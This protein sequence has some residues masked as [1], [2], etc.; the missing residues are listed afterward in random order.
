MSS[1]VH[2]DSSQTRPT[3]SDGMSTASIKSG[4]L[5]FPQSEDSHAALPNAVIEDKLHSTHALDPSAG[6]ASG[7]KYVVSTIH[8]EIINWYSDTTNPSYTNRDANLGAGAL[9]AGTGPTAHE[10]HRQ[11]DHDNLRT[12]TM[13]SDYTDS[14]H[15]STA[16]SEQPFDRSFDRQQSYTTATDR[17][18][19]LSGGVVSD[20]GAG[21]PSNTYASP[22]QTS[23]LPVIGGATSSRGA[24]KPSSTFGSHTHASPAQT[25]TLPIIG[26]RTSGRYAENPSS[27]FG[28][29]S[30]PMTSEREPGT[31]ER[32]AGLSD[33]H[34]REALAGA[35]A[36]V[37]IAGSENSGF[38]AQIRQ[39]EHEHE[40]ERGPA[41]T[42]AA[43]TP[44]SSNLSSAPYSSNA[45]KIPVGSNTSS[46]P[47]ASSTSSAPIFN[48]TSSA[49]ISSNT[50]NIPVP[51]NTS[52]DPMSSNSSSIPGP[53][54]TSTAPS[55]SSILGAP[56]SS[57]T[58]NAPVSDD[59]LNAPYG[60]TSGPHV[61]DTANRL[62][63][64]L[65]VPGEFP[66]TPLET[67]GARGPGF[68]SGNIGTIDEYPT[69]PLT[70][71]SSTRDSPQLGGAPSSDSQHHYG[72]DAA[73]TGGVGAAGLRAYE[74]GKHHQGETTDI[75]NDATPAFSSPYSSTQIDP[76][77]DSR[78]A[79]FEEQRFDPTAPTKP[80][81]HDSQHHG[82]DAALAGGALA[83]ARA[84]GYAAS[85]QSTEPHQSSQPV[86]A[87]RETF[88]TSGETTAQV[89][90]QTETK[91]QSEHHYGRDAGL[92]GAGAAGG[93]YYANQQG[94][95][96]DTG[97]AT[98]TIGPHKSN[99]A[100][101]LDPCVQPD[102][103]LQQHRETGPTAEDP[104]TAT[105]GPH[106]SNV[107][108]ILDPRVQPDPSKQKQHVTTGPHQS[109]TLNRLDPKVDAH[110]QQSESQHH[111]GRDAGVVGGTGAAGYGAYEAAQK[112]DEHRST[113]PT[114]SLGEQRYYPTAHGAH[115]P[116]QT[117]Q[118][119][120]GRDAAVAGGLGTAGAEAYAASRPHDRTEEPGFSQGYQQSAAHPPYDS[121]QDPNAQGQSHTNR[122]LAAAGGAAGLAG[123]GAYA[124][125]KQQDKDAEKERLAHQ[126]AQEKELEHQHKEQQKEFEKKQ[127]EQEKLLHDRQNEFEKQQ[128]AEQKHH[129][130]AVAAEEHAQQKAMEQARHQQETAATHDAGG[131]EKKHHLFGFLHRDKDKKASPESSSTQVAEHDG[132]VAEIDGRHKLHKDP[133][134]KVQEELEKKAVEASHP[135]AGKR[136]HMGIDGPIGDAHQ[137]SGDQ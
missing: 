80:S 59:T 137:I 103:S 41:A 49:P 125:S 11:P 102:K 79:G 3:A 113:Q 135:E 51:S 24:E 6:S 119:H 28:S 94:K 40:Q 90:P 73:I 2:P 97:P 35:A 120:Y 30:Q 33:G 25:S 53:S 106:K 21:N 109:D 26:S 114:A 14:A 112:Y 22:A 131:K 95:Q 57:N 83:G 54:N 84:S 31:K 88:P 76:R 52:R 78:P 48:N 133:P 81:P 65:H 17:A 92:L 43:I 29:H 45:S 105:I 13:G 89:V 124:H 37:A 128:A 75:G 107:A 15:R 118:H 61:T 62:D 110:P 34:G 129:Q 9:G 86:T 134:P 66:E 68:L 85:R 32:A 115:D 12:A 99:V 55:T 46:V 58:S 116:S 8:K 10:L 87:H 38:P 56:V 91:P 96:Q 117:S 64:H 50:S 69:A 5:G 130:K 98:A 123:A 72:R 74:A 7:P 93:A 77:V 100:N 132:R 44:F 71:I 108:N 4:V 101:V 23:T 70:G 111:Y 122:N 18:F 121:V 104:A 39:H 27:V 47:I 42:T 63:P 1:N 127:K 136:E 36:A 82:R 16:T 20:R 67:P 19:P 126:K 60:Y